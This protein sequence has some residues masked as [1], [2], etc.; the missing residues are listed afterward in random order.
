MKVSIVI[1]VKNGEDT[2]QECLEGIFSQEIDFDLE[3]LVIDSGSTDRSLEILASFPVRVIPIPP[4]EFNHGD[5]RNLGAAESDGELIVFFVQ[6]AVPADR[7]WLSRLVRNLLDDPSVAGAFSRVIPRPGCGPLVERGV[8]G[9]L[10]FGEER[11]ELRFESTT[12]PESWDPHTR[13]IRSNYNDVASVM[14][15]SV[16][17]KI[18]YPR[19]PFGEDII[20]SNCVQRAGYTVVFDPSSVVIHSHEYQPFS[21]YPRTHIDGWFNKAYFQRTC[22]EKLSH[23]FIMTWRQ[24]RED[25]LFLKTKD[26]GAVRRW[27]E[28]LTSLIYHFMEVL[29]A[30]MGARVQG[31]TLYALAPVEAGPL[32]ILMVMSDSTGSD[33]EGG[34]DAVVDLAKELIELGHEVVL[35][36]PGPE[37]A[38]AGLS[39]G[40]KDGVPMITLGCEERLDP[41]F[42]EAIPAELGRLFDDVFEEHKPH[43][44]HCQDFRPFT[45]YMA[46]RAGRQGFPC[47]ITLN[48]FWF[49]CARTDLVRPHGIPCLT[50]HPLRLGCAICKGNCPEF[51]FAAGIIDKLAGERVS[52]LFE[53]LDAKGRGKP[54]GSRFRTEAGGMLN[55]FARFMR[56]PET[57]RRAL[58]SVSYIMAPDPFTRQKCIEAGFDEG[59]V[60]MLRGRHS[61]GPKESLKH[62]MQEKSCERKLWEAGDSN[63][64]HTSQ[65]VVKYRQA[66]GRMIYGNKAESP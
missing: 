54:G 11:L 57:T 64:S 29:G 8:R 2:L 42:I 18:P 48:D 13:R 9:D 44:I 16:W 17:E 4:A 45:L 23:V 6:D 7:H 27:R 19:T 26:L 56:R 43:V 15:R 21:I 47:I 49:R 37:H 14:R 61:S 5:T 40:A 38:A 1:P 20:W 58:K 63:P 24:F 62:A 10:N 66:A 50:R 31:E 36:Q 65:M 60:V 41:D 25:R 32:R 3:L 39:Y 52:S 55:R 22:F 53:R 34:A 28:S 33:H 30:Y 46:E 35:L 51:I 12:A 59:K